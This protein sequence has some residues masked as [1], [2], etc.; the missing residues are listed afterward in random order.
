ML[1][2]A[3][4]IPLQASCEFPPSGADEP[5]S[6]KG[7]RRRANPNA[8]DGWRSE[9]KEPAQLLGVRMA[10]VR[11]GTHRWFMQEVQGELEDPQQLELVLSLFILDF[12]EEKLAGVLALH[13]TILPAGSVAGERRCGAWPVC[14]RLEGSMTGMHG[15]GSRSRSWGRSFDEMGCLR[16][17]A[18]VHG[19]TR[20]AFGEPGLRSRPSFRW[21]P[22]ESM[23]LW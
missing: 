15:I 6:P 7:L 17:A 23:A 9:A 21:H 8:R 10:D 1:A 22:D 16:P 20:Q 3:L 11:S 12:A 2:L 19:A 18:Q 4:M 5:C 14:S 13:A